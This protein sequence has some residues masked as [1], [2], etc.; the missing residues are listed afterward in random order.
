MICGIELVDVIDEQMLPKHQNGASERDITDVRRLRKNGDKGAA[1]SQGNT[2]MASSSSTTGRSG[3]P[4]AKI[5]QAD[6]TIVMAGGPPLTPVREERRDLATS[7]L[8][9]GYP[10]GASLEY[11]RREMGATLTPSPSPASG[12][13]EQVASAAEP[14]GQQAFPP[15]AT[16]ASNFFQAAVAFVGDGCALVDDAEYR[17]RLTV[18]HF[19]DR[20]SE[21]RCTACGCWIG[22]KAR[23]R[24]FTCPLDRWK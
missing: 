13:G 21:R 5:V 20:R 8:T 1:I 18:C 23:G 11:G 22:L 19:C 3:K 12:R 4:A 7:A 2:N 16:Q 14:V 6:V 10:L 15:L 17:R 24:A 9:P